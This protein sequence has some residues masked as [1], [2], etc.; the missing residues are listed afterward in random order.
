MIDDR[1]EEDA[2]PTL[3]D[4]LKEAVELLLQQEPPEATATPGVRPDPASPTDYI[5][6][7]LIDPAD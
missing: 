5:D 7:A 1:P 6:P 2:A 4:E 3:E